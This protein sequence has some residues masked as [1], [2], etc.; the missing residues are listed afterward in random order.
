MPEG[1][2]CAF[3]HWRSAHG[4]RRVTRYF[5]RL[6][7]DSSEHRTPPVGS[8]DF[9]EQD[10]GVRCLSP[11]NPIKFLQ[12]L[13]DQ[14]DVYVGHKVED[15]QRGVS[16]ADKLGYLVIE[17]RIAAKS[18]VD[19]LPVK[20]TTQYI[21]VGHPRAR[22]TPTLLDARAITYHRFVSYRKGYRWWSKDSQRINTNL[23]IHHTII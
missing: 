5:Y 14:L 18:E 15:N 23:Q 19:E 20:P 1:G 10:R 3:R 22:S 13:F 7:S 2:G 4:T 9:H 12:P 11:D 21:Q 16:I 17:L 6:R 8:W